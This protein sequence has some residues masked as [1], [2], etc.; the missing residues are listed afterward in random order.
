MLTDVIVWYKN[1]AI[2]YDSCGFWTVQY[3]GDD[4]VFEEL[5]DAYKFIDDYWE[6]I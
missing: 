5:T 1:V 2:E 4:V 6:A 3:C